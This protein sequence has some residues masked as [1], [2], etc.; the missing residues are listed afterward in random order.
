MHV[1]KDSV[2]SGSLLLKLCWRGVATL[3]VGLT[4]I[5]SR[6]FDALVLGLRL[7]AADVAMAA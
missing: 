7:D 2:M 6:G 1:D 4:R 3:D 5:P